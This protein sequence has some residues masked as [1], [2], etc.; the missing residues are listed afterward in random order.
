MYIKQ[1]IE[2]IVNPFFGLI[3]LFRVVFYQGVI[4]HAPRPSLTSASFFIYFLALLFD[5]LILLFTISCFL[6]F[7]ASYTLYILKISVLHL[8][9]V[10]IDLRQAYV[11]NAPSSSKARN[12]EVLLLSSKQQNNSLSFSLPKSPL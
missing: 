4:S 10:F 3:E 5:V 2:V 11:S 1:S 7:F 6:I 12:G 8:K 9:K